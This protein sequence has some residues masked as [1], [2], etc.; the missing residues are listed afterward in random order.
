MGLKKKIIV[1]TGARSEYGLLKPLIQ[2]LLKREE[3][4]TEIAVA[5][6]H[7][8]QSQG[9]TV[10]EIDA[11][12]F[13]VAIKIDHM[14]EVENA[15]AVSK[16]NGQ[17]QIAFAGFLENYKPDLV[18]VLGDRSEL[19][20]V[21][22]SC[23]FQ[24]VPVAHISG[25]EVTEG[26]TDNQV[27]HAVSKMS[28]IHFPATEIYKENLLKMGEEKWRICVAGEP[29]LDEILSLE[30]PGR[31]EFC[32]RFGLPASGQLVIATFHSE[33][34]GQT[35]NQEFLTSLISELCSKTDAHFLF[36]SANTDVG[37]A[38]INDTLRGI[39]E[40]NERVTFVHSLGRTNYYAAQRHSVLMLG[41]SSSGLVEAQ[42]F[43]IPV[44]N[45]GARQDG[46]LRN[47]NVIDVPVDISAIFEAFKKAMHPQFRASIRKV[48]NIYGDGHASERIS[49]FIANIDWSKLLLKRSSF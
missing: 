43:G 31:A 1:F 11:D 10:T 16:S 29:G 40:Q 41:N 7:L 24:S 37:G 27:R 26:A 45:V 13:P 12:N 49:N 15:A 33:T 17:L 9:Y 20:P 34:I 32:H 19:I 8:S 21:V 42:S 23:L 6:G 47:A 5:G 4:E 28:H 36:T 18:I 2:V 25:G 44:I 38:E 39:S 3:F 30:L 14:E 46:R 22:S 35:I 48:P